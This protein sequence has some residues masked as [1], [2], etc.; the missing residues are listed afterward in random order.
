MTRSLLPVGVVMAVC[1]SALGQPAA[2][3]T[4]APRVELARVSDG[5]LILEHTVPETRMAQQTRTVTE[6]G[7]TRNVI[8][9]VPVTVVKTFQEAIPFKEVKAFDM[10]GRS[11]TPGRVGHM[12]RERT[13]VAISNGG[14]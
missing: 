10:D 3:T 11:V 4:P 5:K 12:L 1:S 13:A 8:V 7:V 9:E 6:N 2:L 14:T